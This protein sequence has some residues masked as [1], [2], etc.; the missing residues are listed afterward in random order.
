MIYSNMYN[1]IYIYSISLDLL[2]LPAD[3]P[4]IL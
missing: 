1:N 2:P 3:L 4:T